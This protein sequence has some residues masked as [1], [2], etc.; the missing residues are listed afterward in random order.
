MSNKY[1]RLHDECI[2]A[3]GIQIEVPL[4]PDEAVVADAPLVFCYGH[5]EIPHNVDVYT[6]QVQRCELP[7][8]GCHAC[9]HAV[10]LN[11]Q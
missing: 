9:L 3:R 5:T 8:C 11:P 2:T 10:R 7:L 6:A 1:Q 4:E